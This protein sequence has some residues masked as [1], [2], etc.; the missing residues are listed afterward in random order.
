MTNKLPR[1]S[2]KKRADIVHPGMMGDGT[3]EQ[4]LSERGNP[5]ARSRRR[6]W[7]PLSASKRPRRSHEVVLVTASYSRSLTFAESIQQNKS[8]QTLA[9]DALS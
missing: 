3:E 8:P 1:L 6:R 9:S 7:M 2:T 5:A 4:N